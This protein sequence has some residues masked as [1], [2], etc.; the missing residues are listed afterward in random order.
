MY[1]SCCSPQSWG[2]E[3]L[4]A[5]LC[6]TTVDNRWQFYFTPCFRDPLMQIC[7]GAQPPPFNPDPSVP[8][9]LFP[10]PC[11][12]SICHS[13]SIIVPLF[14]S[15]F[16]SLSICPCPGLYPRSSVLIPQSLLLS[17]S[18]P[19]PVSFTL[20]PSPRP[21]ACRPVFVVLCLSSCP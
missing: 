7:R 6:Y 16:L 21:C 13:P 11:S 5:L 17:I 10:S 3:R 4:D 18:V 19:V 15:L 8:V 12:C 1:Y 9:H 20:S 2:E 14:L